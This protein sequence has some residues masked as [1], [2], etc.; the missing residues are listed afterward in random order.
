MASVPIRN[1]KI[2][3]KIHS[4]WVWVFPKNRLFATSNK[5]TPISRVSVI[6]GKLYSGF[7][8]L[9]AVGNSAPLN[10]KELPQINVLLLKFITI[11]VQQFESEIYG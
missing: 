6:P 7:V 4:L 1:N 3:H 9:K 8:A 5:D 11:F 10:I 2:P